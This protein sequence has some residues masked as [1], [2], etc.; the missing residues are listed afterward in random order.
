MTR[1][2]SSRA[3]SRS[4][5]LAILLIT[6]VVLVIGQDRDNRA[7]KARER[8]TKYEYQIPMRDGV[9]LFTT[10]YVPK[11]D[12]QK[13]PMLMM[14]TPYSVRPYGKDVYRGGVGPNPLFEEEGYI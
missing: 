1:T 8:Y 4:F 10:V 11:D 3:L 13:Y 7:R 6:P 2:P 5:L 12:K 14:R 9:R